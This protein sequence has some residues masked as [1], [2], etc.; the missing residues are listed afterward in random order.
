MVMVYKYGQMEL[1]MKVLGKTI[2]L[3]EMENLYMQMATFMKEIG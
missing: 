1:G 3:T 2:E